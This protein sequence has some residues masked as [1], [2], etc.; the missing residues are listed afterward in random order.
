MEISDKVRDLLKKRKERIDWSLW[1]K[2]STEALRLGII[3]KFE[4]VNFVY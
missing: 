1:H 4:V 2:L 3:I